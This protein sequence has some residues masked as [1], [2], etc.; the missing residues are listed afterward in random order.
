MERDVL[1]TRCVFLQEVIKPNDLQ[2]GGYLI[3]RMVVQFHPPEP[4]N[5]C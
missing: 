5:N 2:S 4:F 1:G 3:Q